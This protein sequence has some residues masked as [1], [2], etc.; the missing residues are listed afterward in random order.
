MVLE[1][2]AIQM[3]FDSWQFRGTLVFYQMIAWGVGLFLF[4]TITDILGLPT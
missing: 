1:A 3:I 2:I 4:D